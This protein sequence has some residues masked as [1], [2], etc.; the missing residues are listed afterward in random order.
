M[1]I[2]KKGFNSGKLWNIMGGNSSTKAIYWII[3]WDSNLDNSGIFFGD[4]AHQASYYIWARLKFKELA[5]II[6]MYI[7][8]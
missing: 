1:C 7:Y 8:I 6:N 4:M 5:S 3:I 2:I